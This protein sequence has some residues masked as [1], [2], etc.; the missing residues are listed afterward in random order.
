M[1]RIG[2][3][4]LGIM[5]KPMAGHLTKAG[6]TLYVHSRTSASVEA[7]AALGAIPCKNPTEVSREI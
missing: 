6:G 2:F 4:G 5:G 7:L 1:L 3:I